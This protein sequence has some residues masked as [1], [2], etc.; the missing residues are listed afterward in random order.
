MGG[1]GLESYGSRDKWRAFVNRVRSLRSHK[2]WGT[3]WLV[4]ELVDICT[5]RLLKPC[6]RVS[7]QVD[8]T[9]CCCNQPETRQR[10]ITRFKT[11]QGTRKLERT[12]LPTHHTAQILHLRFS[13]LWGF[14]DAI[15]GIS[16]GVQWGY[17]RSKE[18]AASIKFKLIQDG[19]RW[20]CFLLAQGCW[21]WWALF[22][23]M[24]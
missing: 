16:L 4:E 6:R 7:G 18:V 20:S 15:H 9:N 22:R 19:E 17:W 21:I 23:K 8:L 1:I 12:V 2:I 11:Q 10:S 5:F 3:S 13:P 14:Q 24:V